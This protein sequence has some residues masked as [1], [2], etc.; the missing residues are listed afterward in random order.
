M[1]YT[2]ISTLAD[3]GFLFAPTAMGMTRSNRDGWPELATN[4]K[5]TLRQWV[6]EGN[7]LVSVAKHGHGFAIDIDDV[8]AVQSRGFQLEWLDGYFLID[9]PS[10]G[11]HAH[12]LHSPETENLGNLVVVYEVSGDTK[13]KK[14]LEL[15]LNNQSVAAPTAVRVN[16]PKKRDGEYKPRG[17][18]ESVMQGLPTAVVEWLKQYAE[19]PKTHRKKASSGIEFHPSFSTDNF[20]EF[21]DCTEYLTGLVD[22]A[23]HVVVESCPICGK[24]A[25]GSTLRAGITKFIFGGNGFG[26]VCHACG[27][28]SR[29]QFNEKMAENYDNWEP[30]SDFIYR[31]DDAALL[32]QDILNDPEC[33]VELDEHEPEPEAGND[34]PSQASAP[35]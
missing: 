8:G 10:G 30:W 19:P 9:T 14:I 18:P 23:F 26:F 1:D 22:D 33:P 31:N 16:Q 29:E 15:K 13:S 12:G 32:E 17:N 4:N 7:N 28:D 5:D 11:I 3:F 21:H 25:N 34:P 24:D 20:L 2:I 35:A 6:N 27:I